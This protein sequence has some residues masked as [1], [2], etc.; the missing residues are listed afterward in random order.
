MLNSIEHHLISSLLIASCLMFNIAAYAEQ[1]PTGD[2]VEAECI[3]CHEKI[4]AKLVTD[5]KTDVHGRNKPVAGC[6]DC[7]GTQ[8][9]NAAI[10][11]R[12]DETCTQCHGGTQASVAH[13]YSTSKHGVINRIERKQTDWSKPFR[14]G[15]YRVPGCAYCHASGG[16][17]N[18]GE[19][20]NQIE[21]DN[22]HSEHNGQARQAMRWM[23]QHCHGPRFIRELQNN[24][25]KM[26]E[27]GN[28]KRREAEAILQTA[29]KTYTPEQMTK[30]TKLFTALVEENVK[31]LYLGIAHQSPDYQWWHGHPAIDG[32][33]LRIKGEL[34]RLN[35]LKAHKKTKEVSSSSE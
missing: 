20:M 28:M 2:Y 21:D 29:K 12:Q 26:L 27:I 13:S 15:N 24:G 7:H 4:S 8:H 16:Q 6:T 22:E 35:R 23:C 14:P 5:W 32:K 25:Q 1:S 30:M 17:H 34:T 31:S 10:L 33:L 9:E 11:S 18:M 19:R 3:T